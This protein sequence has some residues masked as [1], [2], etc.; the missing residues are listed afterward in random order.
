MVTPFWP[1]K[2]PHF[3]TIRR[4]VRAHAAHAPVIGLS[5]GADS[6]ALVAAAVAENLQP[7]AVAIDHGLQ[8]GSADVANQAKTLATELGATAEVVK[9]QVAPGNLEAQ[10]REARYDA[11]HAAA[12]KRQ[13]SLWVAHTADDQAETFLMAAL[14][15]NPTGMSVE[16]GNLVRPLLAVRR[17]DTQGACRELDLEYW[18]DPMN[19][20]EQFLRVALR[21]E[22]LPRLGELTHADAVDN[23][24]Q[25]GNKAALQGSYIAQQARQF[26]NAESL[27]ALALE[28]LHPAVRRQAI[29]EFLHHHNLTVS[30]AILTHIEALITSWRGQG[31]V[32]C[33][34]NTAK[35]LEVVRKN[36]K[37]FVIARQQHA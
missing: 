29:V 33:G 9:V 4:A 26:T 3:L 22:I 21:R 14:R 27:D 24:A 36:G 7:H 11:L 2:S 37:L 28:Q 19:A 23:L 1:D 5:G 25:A 34:G 18:D 13:S 32:A 10:A 17:R 30:T 6:L 12:A 16:E 35:R 15:G 31:G 20:D 8:E